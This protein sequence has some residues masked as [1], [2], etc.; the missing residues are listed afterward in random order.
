MSQPRTTR[1][2]SVAAL[3]AVAV[4][5]LLAVPGQA[6]T[7]PPPGTA[8]E[9]LPTVDDSRRVASDRELAAL[10]EVADRNGT[11]DASVGL[12]AR[13]TPEGQLPPEGVRAQ[14]GAI[15]GAR[16]QLLAALGGTAHEVVFP[17]DTVPLVTLRLSRPAVDALQRSGRAARAEVDEVGTPD[18]ATTTPLVQSVKANQAGFTGAGRYVAIIDTG[19]ENDHPFLAGKVKEEACFSEE[20]LC[21][22]AYEKYGPGSAAPCSVEGCEHGTHVAGIAAGAGPEFSGVAPGASVI[23]IAVQQDKCPPWGFIGLGC[24]K[25]WSEDAALKGLDYVHQLRTDKGL[26]IAA[27]NVSLGFGPLTAGPCDQS[28]WKPLIDNL[29]SVGVATVASAGN[30]SSPDSHRAPGCVSTAVTVGST[31]GADLASLAVTQQSNSSP[32]V[33]LLAPNNVISSMLDGTFGLQGGT[34]QATPHVAG[35]FAVLRQVAP[36]ATVTALENALETTGHPV[37]D[38]KNG[39]TR[40]FLQLHAAATVFTPH[41]TVADVSVKEGD[42]PFTTEAV[43]TVSRLGNTGPAITADFATV[44]GSASAPTD[45]GQAAGSLS[46]QPGQKSTTVSV[47]VKGDFAD[48]TDEQ[49]GLKL[50]NVKG[51]TTTFADSTAIATIVDDEKPLGGPTY[52]SGQVGITGTRVYEGTGGTTMAEFKVWLA[53]PLPN[54][55]SVNVVTADFWF[56]YPEST[57]W[58]NGAQ[59][60][61]DFVPTNKTVVFHTGEVEKTVEIP[62][63]ADATPE[64]HELFIVYLDKPF[65]LELIDGSYVAEGWIVNDD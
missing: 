65:N 6:Q 25:A 9:S 38:A 26:P 19:V 41:V 36:D 1:K 17:F 32:L 49:F 24:T 29:R 20:K 33:D 39:V 37:T 15:A 52:V 22:G 47:T 45:Y 48:E 54:F 13:F 30:K 12:Q 34:S 42:K 64:G 35:A 63:R 8:G 60:P 16:E 21:G 44:D 55:S 14:R 51:A 4:L 50:S 58:A 11:V 3:A 62:I 56:E 57:D 23:A 2:F 46:L 5:T 59:E 40:P 28:D 18:L 7:A 43:F 27:A 53:A 31:D 61:P 10:A